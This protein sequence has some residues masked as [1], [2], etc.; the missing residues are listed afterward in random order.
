M[1]GNGEEKMGKNVVRLPSRRDAPTIEQRMA[2]LRHN[3]GR[4]TDAA[5][6][7]VPGIPAGQTG[8]GEDVNTIKPRSA[9]DDARD[10]EQLFEGV[11]LKVVEEMR[12]KADKIL[13]TRTSAQLY[14][15]ASKIIEISDHTENLNQLI[16][17]LQQ[18]P[19]QPE[20]AG[21]YSDDDVALAF[22]F[23]TLSG[24]R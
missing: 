6:E 24:P 4:K 21:G 3:P 17:R 13:Q 9:Q 2:K 19:S 14:A 1:G 11:D 16:P 23:I 5:H 10:R 18:I 7:E 20:T 8:E 22:A 15:L 12:E